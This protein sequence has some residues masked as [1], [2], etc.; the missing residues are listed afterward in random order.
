MNEQK[1]EQ[2]IEWLESMPWWNELPYAHLEAEND[3]LIETLIACPHCGK[4]AQVTQHPETNS[5]Q[6]R[7]DAL[8]KPKEK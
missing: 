7:D 5:A 4:T 6:V 8:L 2:L 3:A 1:R